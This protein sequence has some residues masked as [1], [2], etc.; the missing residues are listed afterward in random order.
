MYVDTSLDI[1]SSLPRTELKDDSSSLVEGWS[2]GVKRVGRMTMVA[3][4]ANP[5]CSRQF[6]EL[7]Q[8]RLFVLPL[9]NGTLSS[10]YRLVKSLPECFFARAA[11][12]LLV[13]LSGM[14]ERVLHG[15]PI[16]APHAGQS[17]FI[18]FDIASMLGRREATWVR[19]GWR[20]LCRRFPFPWFPALT[21]LRKDQHDSCSLREGDL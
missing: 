2:L 21:C 20:T 7:S 8:G 15:S 6:Q 5:S 1:D 17:R 13:W 12:F 9:F 18:D 16:L 14:P 10:A 19:W 3:K 4:C 11:I